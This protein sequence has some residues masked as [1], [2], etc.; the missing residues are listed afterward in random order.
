ML[1]IDPGPSERKGLA[2][3]DPERSEGHFHVVPAGEA[4]RWIEGQ[5]EE[6][7]AA[8]R[9]LLIGWDAPLSADF[10]FSYTQRPIE[11]Y[12]NSKAFKRE[13]NDPL[14]PGV[15][16]QG[17]G[18]C[19]HWTISVDVLGH[20]SPDH[21]APTPDNRLA[22]LSPDRALD[23]TGVLET[24]PALAVAM[25]WS[26]GKVPKYKGRVKKGELRADLRKNVKRITAFL[27]EQALAHF[28]AAWEDL[29]ANYCEDDDF[30]DAEV[31][32]LCVAA[33][34]RGKAILLGDHRMGGFT[35]P[36]TKRSTV[37]QAR[38]K[39]FEQ[40]ALKKRQKRRTRTWPRDPSRAVAPPSE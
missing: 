36:A 6:A 34:L 23:V 28:G 10:A 13:F 17:Y 7:S 38:Y 12:L 2:V 9:P 3:Y 4:R 40:D 18:G 29:P 37:A 39:V 21:L 8:G 25:C 19:P 27:A 14:T 22:L 32:Y 15:S 16:V 33:A 11:Q 30:L 1:G 31:S 20:P 5:R 24:H 26:D 35:V